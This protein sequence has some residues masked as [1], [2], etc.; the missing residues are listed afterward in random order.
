M[1]GGGRTEGLEGTAEVTAGAASSVVTGPSVRRGGGRSAAGVDGPAAG[2]PGSVSIGPSVRRGGGRSPMGA[3]GRGRGGPSSVAVGPSVR[4]E[5]VRAAS[6]VG[7]RASGDVRGELV[8]GGGTLNATDP[9]GEVDGSGGGRTLRGRAPAGIGPAS[10]GGRTLRGGGVAERPPSPRL[11]GGGGGIVRGGIPGPAGLA[12]WLWLGRGFGAVTGRAAR[13]VVPAPPIGDFVANSAGWSRTLL[14]SAP[15]SS[16]VSLA[17]V[18]S[19]SLGAGWRRVG[20]SSTSMSL[21]RRSS[22][23]SMHAI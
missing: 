9:A 15:A 3:E 13:G 20:S 14:T 18:R 19:P 5:G 22:V 8:G 11:R 2:A 1:R 4:P 17:N 21:S 10:G 6:G 16:S 23:I 12:P 7:G